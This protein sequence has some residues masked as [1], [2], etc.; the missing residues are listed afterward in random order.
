MVWKLL[1]LWGPAY[2]G[3]GGYIQGGETVGFQWLDFGH[4]F[5]VVELS[6]EAPLSENQVCKSWETPKKHLSAWATPLKFNMEPENQ[7]LEKEIP[8]GNHHFQV[9]C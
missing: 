7:P 5:G 1:S 9:P 3:P 4:L 6:T 8:F 2:F